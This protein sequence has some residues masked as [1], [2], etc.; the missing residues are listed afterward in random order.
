MTWRAGSLSLQAAK[1]TAIGEASLGLAAHSRSD[2]GGF[3]L[4]LG[5]KDEKVHAWRSTDGMIWD[6]VPVTGMTA[7]GYWFSG[8]AALDGGG[9]VA[10]GAR[11]RGSDQVPMAWR[12]D[13]GVTWR[14][15]RVASSGYLSDVAASG[16]RVVAVGA[17]SLDKVTRSGRSGLPTIFVSSDRGKTWRSRPVPE[18]STSARFVTGLADVTAG[19]DGFAAGG[20]YYDEVQRTYRPFVI[21]AKNPDAWRRTQDLPSSGTSSSIAD[22]L[23]VGRNV[24]AVTSVSAGTQDS[25]E[26][27]VKRSGT[28]RALTGPGSDNSL[29]YESG[30]ALGDQA[31]LSVTDVGRLS[32]QQL[33]RLNAD[34]KVTSTVV[35]EDPA[36]RPEL[37]PQAL[38]VVDGKVAAYGTAQGA[39][40]YWPRSGDTFEAPRILVDKAGEWVDTLSW[41]SE[42]GFLA[43]CSQQENAFTLHSADGS[44]WTRTKPTTFNKVAQYHYAS[45]NAASFAHGRWVVVG[46][47]STNGSVRVS[48]FA[49]TSTNGT[50]WTAG[51]A[52][53]LL[54]R[55]DYFGQNSPLTDLAGLDNNARSMHAVT[56]LDKGL[57]AVGSLTRGAATRPAVWTAPDARVWTLSELKSGKYP[58]AEIA[59]VQRVGGAL[60]ATGWA[61]PAGQSRWHAATWRSDDRG[62]HWSFDGSLGRQSSVITA[63]AA[64][65]FVQVIVA[66]DKQT[67]TVRRSP[68]GLTWTQSPLEVTGMGDGI[69][70]ELLDAV[71]AEGLLHVL[72]TLRNRADEVTVVQTLPM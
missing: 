34:L 18:P 43:T 51:K 14:S 38:V 1:E 24:V 59:G 37:I 26:L 53:R 65:Q 17:R 32:A 46:D 36:A 10:T 42:G 29:A 61:R 60:L 58:D 44:T 40:V 62:V 28:W 4:A 5:V 49:F 45:L 13:D 41:S 30:I 21:T 35:P 54:G 16:N 47:R 48:A 69:E 39:G 27:A 56:A 12:S 7:E 6:R 22:L 11:I 64:D 8:L 20:S 25:L 72:L 63:A 3:W 71:V 31:L 52:R 50:S 23:T 9:F 68:D 66:E 67:V 70:V 57:I 55:G 33:W 19:P 2:Q 15:R